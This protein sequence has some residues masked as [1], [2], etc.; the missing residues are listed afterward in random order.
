MTK[1]IFFGIFGGRGLKIFHVCC[2]GQNINIY[3]EKCKKKIKGLRGQ[4][5]EL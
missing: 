5:A 4:S 2:I 3:F 1:L